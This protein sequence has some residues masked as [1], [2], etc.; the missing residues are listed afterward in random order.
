MRWKR[1]AMALRLQAPAER[2]TGKAGVILLAGGH[3]VAEVGAVHD[4]RGARLAADLGLDASDGAGHEPQ[5]GRGQV[6]RRAGPAGRFLDR[7]GELAEGKI[8]RAADLEDAAAS[9]GGRGGGRRGG[10]G[11]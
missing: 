6:A 2:R 10:G 7:G 5:D 1:P 9:G 11:G 3:V 4:E 8:G